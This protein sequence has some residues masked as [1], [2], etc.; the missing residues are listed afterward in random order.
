MFLRAMGHVLWPLDGTS[1]AQTRYSIRLLCFWFAR[2]LLER[3]FRRLG[4]PLDILEV[5]V[6]VGGDAELR[7]F[8]GAQNWIARW[9]GLDVNVPAGQSELY[10]EFFEA[11]IEQDLVLPRTYD[12]VVLSHVLEH[13]LEP[14]AAMARLSKALAAGGVLIGGSPTMPSTIGPVRERFLRRK[15]RG[16][17]VT[18]HRHMSV[19]TPSRIRRVA[20]DCSLE[21]ELIAGTFFIRSSG[22]FLENY[23][24]WIRANLAWGAAFP[25]LGGELYFSLRKP[26][27]AFSERS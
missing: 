17:P 10:D 3:H 20:R 2:S 9:D 27:F 18:A 5:G 4:R 23:A 26:A 1:S 16:V 11:D 21:P 7:A 14:E 25:S 22:S 24:A 15:N 6:G 8:I 12:A 13:L 19:I